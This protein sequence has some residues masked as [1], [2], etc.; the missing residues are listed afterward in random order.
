VRLSV[1]YGIDFYNWVD[2]GRYFTIYIGETL[3]VAKIDFTYTLE[4]SLQATFKEVS[5]GA[6]HVNLQFLI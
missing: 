5:T 1:T 6:I 4:P 2:R 3:G